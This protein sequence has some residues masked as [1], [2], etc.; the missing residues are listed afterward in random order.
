MHQPFC[1]MLNGIPSSH[2]MPRCKNATQRMCTCMPMMPWGSSAY[3]ILTV[4]ASMACSSRRHAAAPE[5]VV[6]PAARCECVAAAP[7]PGSGPC[8]PCRRARRKYDSLRR[9]GATPSMPACAEI[10]RPGSKTKTAL[11]LPTAACLPQPRPLLT[12]PLRRLLLR[13]QRPWQHRPRSA[14]ICIHIGIW[15]Q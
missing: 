9:T 3:S 13:A 6:S 4:S 15:L 10:C 5:R 12:A 7:A 1:M 2:V 11:D 8:M 14:H